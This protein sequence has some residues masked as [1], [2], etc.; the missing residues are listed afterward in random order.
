MESH[1]TVD[2]RKKK[3]VESSWKGQ[4]CKKPENQFVT[5]EELNT[6][7]VKC[8]K[9]VIK[10]FTKVNGL[11]YESSTDSSDGVST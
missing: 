3:H 2:C 8:T 6:L 5:T 7:V 10:C 4:K 11:T 1:G 9:R